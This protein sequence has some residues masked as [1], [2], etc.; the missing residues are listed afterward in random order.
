MKTKYLTLFIACFIIANAFAQ[1]NLNEYKYVIVPNKFE[2]LKEANKYRLNELSQFLF[3]KYGFT[4][5]ME[6]SEYPEDLVRDRCLALRSNVTKD[7]GMFRT[8]LNVTLK[9]CNDKVVYISGTGESREKEFSTAYNYALREAFKSIKALNYNYQ[10]KKATRVAQS[11]EIVETNTTETKE[12]IEKLKQELATLKQAKETVTVNEVATEVSKPV[13]NDVAIKQSKASQPSI[14]VN[15]STTN[16]LYAQ[17]IPNGFQLVDSTPK[18]LHKLKNTGLDN[19]FILEDKNAI[20]YKKGESW[21]LEYYTN[22]K[23]KQEQLNIKF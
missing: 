17:A 2:F 7:S 21:I 12:E 19:V 5:I 4:A 9:D 6:G 8:K 23:L 14:G 18:V 11:T 10:P 1:A 13:K 16:V 20:I 15:T 3:N 22:G